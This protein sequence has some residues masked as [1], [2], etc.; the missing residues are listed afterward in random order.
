MHQKLAFLLL[1]CFFCFGA[2]AQLWRSYESDTVSNPNS[3]L[4]LNGVL[5]Y[6]ASSIENSVLNPLVFGGFISPEAKDQSLKNHRGFQVLGAEAQGDLFYFKK[7]KGSSS[8]WN[9]YVPGIHAGY[10]QMASLA[11]TSDLYTLAFYGNEAFRGDYC[12]L[13]GTQLKWMGFQ[14]FGFSLYDTKNKASLG[15]NLVG[16]T[17]YSA[18][19]LNTNP[20]M[21]FYYTESGDSLYGICKASTSYISGKSFYKGMGLSLDFDYEFKVQLSEDH[22]SPMKISLRNFGFVSANNITTQSLDTSFAFGGFTLTELIQR[23]GV[24]A[25]GFSFTDSL[26]QSITE[27]RLL[28]LP[29]S[30]QL[31]SMY[32]PSRTTRLQPLL[33]LRMVFIPGYIPFVYAGVNSRLNQNLNLALCGSYG[34][35][36]GFKMNAALQFQKGAFALGLGSDN[37]LG[38]FLKSAFGKALSIQMRCV[39]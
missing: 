15:L 37:L 27:N 25:P 30:I 29:A 39:F 9:R 34:G 23:E 16:L 32:D 21:R 14:S 19:D 36:S 7:I 2:N 38:L 17:H 28:F 13:T 22:V 12:D 6:N 18:A 26:T 3:M 33:G 1:V 24:L 20:G 4:R 10:S 31:M 35:F 8:F 11:Y 5:D